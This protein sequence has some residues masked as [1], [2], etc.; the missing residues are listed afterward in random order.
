MAATTEVVWRSGHLLLYKTHEHLQLEPFLGPDVILFPLTYFS[1][2]S[3]GI[4]YIHPAGFM[5]P[6]GQL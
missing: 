5:Q 1:N 2:A 6:V 3:W 4:A